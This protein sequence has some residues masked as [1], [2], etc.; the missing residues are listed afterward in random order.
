MPVSSTT[1]VHQHH[2][3]CAPAVHIVSRALDHLRL[4]PAPLYVQVLYVT[5]E[6]LATVDG[7]RVLVSGKV[8]SVMNHAF[9]PDVAHAAC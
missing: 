1:R 7:R 3:S 8:V 5:P 4:I 6:L 9:T 2:K